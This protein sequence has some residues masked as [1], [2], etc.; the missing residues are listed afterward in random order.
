[1]ADHH[2]SGAIVADRSELHEVAEALGVTTAHV[3]LVRWTDG[4]LAAF[5]A[6]DAGDLH[7]RRSVALQG[8]AD[9]PAIDPFDMDAWRVDFEEL[10]AEVERC[11]DVVERALGSPQASEVRFL[12]QYLERDADGLL[13][14]VGAPEEVPDYPEELA[15]L[16][17][18]AAEKRDAEGRDAE[19]QEDLGAKLAWLRAMGGEPE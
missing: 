8:P 14:R 5:Y 19:G 6:A 13:V 3:S 9:P 10:M 2:G 1:M 18:R 12:C 15:S 16:A 17:R 7:P 4:R 11:H